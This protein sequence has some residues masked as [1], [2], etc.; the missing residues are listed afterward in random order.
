M[1]TF[2]IDRQ[3]CYTSFNEVHKNVM[4]KLY[5]SQIR[6]GDSILDAMKNPADRATAKLNLERAMNGEVV[7]EEAFSGND[8]NS[9]SYFQVTHFPAKDENGGIIGVIVIA[10]DITDRKNAEIV[11]KKN[12]ELEKMNN[13]MVGREMAMV[14]L[15]KRV[16]ELEKQISDTNGIK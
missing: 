10:R 14:E 5:G 1:P 2:S 16:A 13:Y 7:T 6:I 15:K 3:Y 8:Q 4:Q 9:L 12:E 11:R